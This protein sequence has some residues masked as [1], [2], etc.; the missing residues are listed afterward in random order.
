ML[1]RGSQEASNQAC[2]YQCSFNVECEETAAI[3]PYPERVESSADE[4]ELSLRLLYRHK[5]VFAVGHGCAAD[6]ITDC[7]PLLMSKSVRSET[8]PIFEQAPIAPLDLIPGVDLSM[9]RMS[10]M[11]W[12]ELA[13]VCLALAEAYGNWIKNKGAEL[14][15]DATLSPRLRERGRAHL[16]NCQECLVRM[17]AGIELLGADRNVFEAF[18]EMNHAMVAQRAHYELSSVAEKRRTWRKEGTEYIPER[19]YEKPQYPE[20]TSWRPFQLAS[21]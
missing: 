3:L 21:S 10:R 9:L 16:A 1:H 18:A 8:M 13:Q 6:W 15:A 12:A 19:P 17:N 5:P 2:L 11:S 14:E 4:E 20:K 7:G